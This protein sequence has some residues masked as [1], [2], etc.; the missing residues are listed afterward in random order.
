MVVTSTT[1]EAARRRLRLTRF[2]LR[3]YGA[4][5]RLSSI[6]PPFSRHNELFRGLAERW[7]IANSLSH[8]HR[9]AN[10]LCYFSLYINRRR[11]LLERPELPGI[12]KKGPIPTVSIIQRP[13]AAGP[14]LPYPSLPES[15]GRS[16]HG[17]S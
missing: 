9:S 13:R 17:F 15:E 8:C 1:M 5:D 3:S 4:V 11:S 2:L 12:S 7:Q 16:F 10:T 6:C 14:S